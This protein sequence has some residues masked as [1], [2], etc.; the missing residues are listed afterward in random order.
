MAVDGRFVLPPEDIDD[1]RQPLPAKPS[2]KRK[3]QRAPE[4]DDDDEREKDL[5]E[6]VLNGP[7]PS[8]SKVAK[9]SDSDDD[10]I[11][12]D[13]DNDEFG[14][15]EP[16]NTMPKLLQL[17]SIESFNAKVDRTGIIYLSRIPPGMG[18]SK[19]KHILSQHGE[20]GRIYLVAAD[21]DKKGKSSNN[22]DKKH[23]PHR[24]VE[25]WIEFMD[26]KVARHTAEMLNAKVIGDAAV[27]KTKGNK[28]N[29]G[30]SKWRDDVWTM[31]YLPRFKWNMLS[32]QVGM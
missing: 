5:Y 20:T 32:E 7:L 21:A 30:A 17:D 19:V 12:N 13:N 31:K 29:G 15:D 16:L 22:A 27:S 3:R 25:G 8:T 23:K 1:L 4:A 14:D 10:V 6:Q 2:K 24:F 9:A 26:K 28:R 18:P 11:D